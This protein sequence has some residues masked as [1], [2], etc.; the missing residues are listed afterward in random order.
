MRAQNRL[1]DLL[2]PPDVT[3]VIDVGCGVG[4]LELAFAKRSP[5]AEI[6]GVDRSGEDL[7][8]ARAALRRG[9]ARRAYLARADAR[10]LPLPSS[11]ADAVVLMAVLHW[12]RPREREALREISRVLKPGGQLV[13]G[14]MVRK[15]GL[16][17]FSV[18]ADELFRT[19]AARLSPSLRPARIPSFTAQ[20]W[21]TAGLI[22][23]LRE[24]GFAVEYTYEHLGRWTFPDGEAVLQL[25]DRTMG[26]F[27]ASGLVPK[28]WS[29]LRVS[30]VKTVNAR[31]GPEGV[32]IRTGSLYLRARK[33]R[34]KK[35]PH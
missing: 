13:L 29:A 3:R 33:V 8:I 2:D 9:K 23:L 11:S 21:S 34:P 16:R 19:A 31:R 20:N 27:Y 26:G 1:L 7:A 14:N 35:R 30:F 18:V 25:I 28:V 10:E 17:Q 12:L 22:R 24:E 15:S 32:K 6:I 5:R 4:T